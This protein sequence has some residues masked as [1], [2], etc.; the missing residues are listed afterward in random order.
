MSDDAELLR[1]TLQVAVP[2]W[3]EKLRRQAWSDIAARMPEL[4]N[5]IASKGDVI[6][7]RGKKRGE[8]AAAFNALAEAVAAMSFVPGGVQ[9]FGIRFVSV[10]PE[11]PGQ[12]TGFGPDFLVVDD[13]EK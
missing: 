8:T 7:Y 5:I 1:L 9:V 3:Q 10:H 12:I 6:L 11:V 4:S 13:P 2:M